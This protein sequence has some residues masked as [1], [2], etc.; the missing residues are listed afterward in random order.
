MTLLGLGQHAATIG[1]AL[2]ALERTRAESRAQWD[3]DARRM[4]DRRY[5]ELIVAEGKKACAELERLA[6]ELATSVRALNEL[7]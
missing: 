2:K 4:F 5:G 7:S 3:D 6:W 1:E